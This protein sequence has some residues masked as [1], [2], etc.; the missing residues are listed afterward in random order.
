[1]N[2]IKLIGILIFGLLF[3]GPIQ[4]EQTSEKLILEFFY[5]PNCEPCKEPKTILEKLESEYSSY[6][7]IYWRNMKYKEPMELFINEYKLSKRPALVFN[8]NS[9]T[10]IYNLTKENLTEKINIYITN[11][12]IKIPDSQQNNYIQDLT[13]PIVIISGLIDGFNPCAFAILAFYL[14]F[15]YS[16]KQKRKNILGRGI[17]YILGIF[18][19][20]ILLGLGIIQ[21]MNFFGIVHPFGIIGILLLIVFGVINLR[22]SF[23]YEK[24]ILKFPRIA[25]SLVRKYVESGTLPMSFI[26]GFAVSLFEFPCS[27]GIYVAI[28]LLIANSSIRGLGYLIIYNLMFVVPLIIIL[29]LASNTNMLL[30]IDEWRVINRKKLSLISGVLLIS[31]ALFTWYILFY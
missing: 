10:A 22:D 5:H 26:L 12:T 9:S 7:K 4:Q 21:T 15:L 29:L 24:P 27:G 16:I 11:D 20:Y 1:M 19:G 17:T 23:T 30:K 28:T 2:G 14:S 6:I 3:V 8:R 31:L 18:I 25:T 13:L